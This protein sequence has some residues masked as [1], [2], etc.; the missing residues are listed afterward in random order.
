MAKKI[1]F[2]FGGTGESVKRLHN[3]YEMD[4]LSTYP[5][6]EDV[7]RIYF[8]GCHASEVGGA[9][10]GIGYIS[11]NLDAVGKKIRSCFNE[12]GV[13]SLTALKNHFGKAIAIEPEE[14]EVE[15][16]VENINLMGFSRGGVTCFSAARHLNDLGIEMRLFARD[17]VPGNSKK[18]AQKISS[19]FYKNHDLRDCTHL[20]QAQILLGAYEKKVNPLHNKYFRQM[21]P[22]F[23]EHCDVAIYRVPKAHHLDPNAGS[24]NQELDFL[25]ANKLINPTH[26]I[27]PCRSSFYMIHASTD[28]RQ[29]SFTDI[30]KL[31]RGNSA[32]ILFNEELFYADSTNETITK[33]ELT[34][35]NQRDAYALKEEIE[36]ITMDSGGPADDYELNLIISLTKFSPKYYDSMLFVPKILRQKDHLSTIERTETLPS[37]KSML[38]A[39]VNYLHPEIKITDSLKTGQALYALSLASSSEFKNTLTDKVL[40]DASDQGKALREFIVE[41]ENINHHVFR[42][43]T[44]EKF[45]PVMNYLRDFIYS[46]LSRFQ[47]SDMTL[48]QQKN[49]CEELFIHLKQIQSL[50]PKKIY[51]ELKLLLTEFLKENVLFHPELTRYIDETESFS[52]KSLILQDSLALLTVKTAKTGDELAELLYHMSEKMRENTYREFP[53]DITSVITNVNQ[54]G[55][56]LRFLPPKHIELLLNNP[57]ITNLITNRVELKQ[58][59]AK[60]FNSEQANAVYQTVTHTQSAKA[61]TRNKFGLYAKTDTVTSN[62][63]TANTEEK[64][65]TPKT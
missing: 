38:H 2:I 54:L 1:L 63:N 41:F 61:H 27:Y 10:A 42:K 39:Q 22:L 19:E 13:L 48:I 3:T 26:A 35:D 8:T 40:H 46:S 62:S 24:F 7:L 21:A 16:D 31:S 55:D 44:M 60:M 59:M 57:L 47:T 49:F 23:D 17:P 18:N 9:K 20:K 51:K 58:V 15:V 29:S 43:T 11:P 53:E 4:D 12:Q 33:I 6:E 64:S 50:V 52:E 14:S 30:K 37:Y 32:V 25:T 28:P 5:F 56:V 65:S 34:D 36:Q 45:K